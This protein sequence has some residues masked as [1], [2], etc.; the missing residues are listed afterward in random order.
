MADIWTEC[1]IWVAAILTIAVYSFAYR[2]NPLFK[3][4][5]HTFV[6]V[7]VGYSFVQA[8]RGVKTFGIDH[9]TAGEALYIIPIILGFLM[10]F[11][12]HKTLYWL[13]RYGISIIVGVGI[14]ASFVRDIETSFLAQIAATAGINIIKADP[15][16]TLGNI[17][18]LAAVA[19]TLYYFIFTFP[20]LHT[21]RAKTL[22]DAGRWFMMLAFGY[23][24]AKTVVTRYNLMLGRLEFLLFEWLK[25]PK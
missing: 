25:L 19:T 18:F 7:A 20:M 8:I 13:Y 24:F 9:L 16:A 1:G 11:R 14:A 4:A 23:A 22:A 12:Y 6:G 5:E 2:D 10:Y 17:V 15:A 3:F 21:G